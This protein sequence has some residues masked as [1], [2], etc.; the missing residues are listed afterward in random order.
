M[1]K[2]QMHRLLQDEVDLGWTL[3]TLLEYYYCYKKKRGKRCMSNLLNL[4]TAVSKSLDNGS[5]LQSSSFI[6]VAAQVI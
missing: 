4:C 3:S 2:V 6:S 1:G 5:K